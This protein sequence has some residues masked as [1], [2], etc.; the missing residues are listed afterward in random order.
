M[1]SLTAEPTSLDMFL[2]E[3]TTSVRPLSILLTSSCLQAYCG[4][5]ENVKDNTVSI[6]DT[7][8]KSTKRKQRPGNGV[9]A[10][11]MLITLGVVYGDLGTSPLYAFKSMMNGQDKTMDKFQVLGSLSL[12]F[13]FI[14]LVVTVKYV[15]TA[16]RADNHGEGGVFAL[17]SAVRKYWKHIS[18]VAMIG[19]AAFLADSVFTPAVSITSSVEGLGSIPLIGNSEAW[20]QELAI[21]LTIVIIIA[22]FLIQHSGTSKLGKM[23]GPVML[24]WFS[25]MAVMGIMSIIKAPGVLLALDPTMGI[26]FLFSDENKIGLAIMGSVFLAMTGAEALYSDMG[27]VGRGNVWATWPFVNFCLVCSYFGQGAWALNGGNLKT[28]DISPFFQIMPEPI[29]PIG[30]VLALAAG[31]IASQALISGAF[32]LIAAADG[33]NWL[34]R[35]KMSY[36]GSTKGQMYIPAVDMS[37]CV[38]TIFVVLF[39]KTSDAMESAYGLA[40]IIAMMMD[41]VLLFFFLRKVKDRKKIAVIMCPLFLLVEL[42]FLYASMSKLLEGGYVA[43]LLAVALFGMF[44][45][46]SNGSRLETNKRSRIHAED[47]SKIL[48]VE[49][50]NDKK[51]LVSDNLVYLTPDMNMKDV[52]KDVALSM[53]HHRANT[54]WVVSILQSDQ[55]YAC[56]WKVNSYGKILHRVRIRLGYKM[57][58]FYLQSYMR[59]IM[60]SML[61]T[62]EIDKITPAWPKLASKNEKSGIGAVKYVLMHRVMSPESQL[63]ESDRT[64]LRLYQ[65]LKKLISRPVEWFGLETSDP[66]IDTVPLW[67]GEEPQ[68]TMT[69][70]N[71]RTAPKDVDDSSKYRSPMMA[72]S[73]SKAD[74]KESDGQ[75]QL[76]FDPDATG[77]MDPIDV[78]SVIRRQKN[79]AV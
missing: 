39:F 37:L 68:I 46:C 5:V 12:I 50:K 28:S 70:V 27:H 14:A 26:R 64:L 7:S 41:S 10:A 32:T 25:F 1:L 73:V 9:T 13:W 11:G 22:L 6:R 16:M 2:K 48:Q 67:R 18:V 36:P 49:V 56:D 76:P 52:E 21:M 4:M 43:V 79:H 24:V 47:L 63:P 61:K 3:S 44:W 17:F 8:T 31:I 15:L 71:S 35:L 19:G 60:K 29:R 58:Q 75:E 30:V 65:S 33:L 77:I 62:G 57:P 38:L 69:R 54:Y 42:M 20:S 78:S 74:R 59:E 66:I 53:V 72:S 40:L 51:D 55:P 34:P 23:F 45:I